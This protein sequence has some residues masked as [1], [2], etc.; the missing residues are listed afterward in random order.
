MTRGLAGALMVAI[1]Y[2]I[3]AEVFGLVRKATR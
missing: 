3:S 1:V 2:S